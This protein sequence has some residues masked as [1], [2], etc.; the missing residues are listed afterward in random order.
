[1]SKILINVL[2]KELVI[3]CPSFENEVELLK[4]LSLEP[5][6]FKEDFLTIDTLVNF[7]GTQYIQKENE[8]KL[9]KIQLEVKRGELYN[10]LKVSLISSK[11]NAKGEVVDKLPTEED[12]KSNIMIDKEYF[13]HSKK[14]IDLECEKNILENI[15]WCLK[16]KSEKL[17]IVCSNI[18]PEDFVSDVIENKMQKVKAKK[19]K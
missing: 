18:Q 9:C 17:N 13:E 19:N 7:F 6:N 8:Y 14:I 15:F 3:K 1:M 5:Q 4:M 16:S 10:K 11:T 12:I 2:G